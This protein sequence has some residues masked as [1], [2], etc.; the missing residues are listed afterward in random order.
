MNRVVQPELLDE[1]PPDD[2]RAIHSRRDL[3]RLNL[4]M[5]HGPMLCDAL[6]KSVRQPPQTLVEIGAGDGS[7]MLQLA[8]RLH[9]RWP[10]VQVL[11]LDRHETVANE[12]LS[13]IRALGWQA[14]SVTADVFDWLASDTN[15]CDAMIANLFLH[16]FAGD[17][18]AELLR[19]AA[20][21]TN[22][23]VACET[24]R[25]RAALAMCSLLPAIG[26]N[27]VT[28]HDA[29]LSV[30]AGFAG[31]ELSAL[32]PAGDAWRLTERR[33][34]LVTHLFSATRNA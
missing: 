28:R 5:R 31:H 19:L 26:C 3:Q 21:R 9:K 32:W 14:Q 7:L 17:K 15:R 2:P 20:L 34:M 22:C 33:S 10:N 16:H 18:L 12:T 29:R 8:Q 6:L 1:L 13:S 4:L 11:L 27:A 23:L 24:R 25:S 30:R